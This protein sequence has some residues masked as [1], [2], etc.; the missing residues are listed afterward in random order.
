MST[1]DAAGAK[2]SP[3]ARS[4][5]LPFSREPTSGPSFQSM[6][7]GRRQVSQVVLNDGLN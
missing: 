4:I 6:R 5:A 7:S 1:G 3:Q 2:G